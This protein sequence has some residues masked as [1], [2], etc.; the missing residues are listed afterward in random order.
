MPTTVKGRFFY[1]Y[2]MQD[3]FS[4]KLVVNEVHESESADHASDL[5]SLACL[6]EKT[7]GRPL[8]LHS[9]N[10]SVMKGGTML[11]MM[12]YLGVQPSYSRPRVSNDNAYAEAL[13]RTAKYCPPLRAAC[14]IVV[15]LGVF[16]RGWASSHSGTACRRGAPRWQG[17]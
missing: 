17:R 16:V 5:L 1:W 2:M 7:A 14:L 3:I 8:V 12:G 4:R 13:F 15:C 11:A 10:G 6:R 9:D